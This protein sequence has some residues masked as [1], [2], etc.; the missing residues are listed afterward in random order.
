MN[1]PNTFGPRKMIRPNVP[2][3]L[4]PIHS[5]TPKDSNVVRRNMI[6]PYNA[7]FS[8]LMPNK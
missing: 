7:S 5:S 1:R 3:P 2:Q 8:A 4:G 6:E